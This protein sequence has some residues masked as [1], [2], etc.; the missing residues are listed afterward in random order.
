LQQAVDGGVADESAYL[1]LYE[2]EL[3]AM[4]PRATVEQR[5]PM[6]ALLDRAVS[7]GSGLSWGYYLRA[8]HRLD[9]LKGESVDWQAVRADLQQGNTA[10]RNA[11]P[12]AFPQSYVEEQLADEGR[13]AGSRVLAGAVLEYGGQVQAQI[14]LSRTVAHATRVCLA[15]CVE[16]NDRELAGEM[17]RCLCRMAAVDAALPQDKLDAASLMRVI[18]FYLGTRI[19]YP[20]TSQQREDVFEA[21]RWMDDA[22]AMARVAQDEEEQTRLSRLAFYQWLSATVFKRAGNSGKT[23]PATPPFAPR[24]VLYQLAWE[25]RVAERER[26]FERFNRLLADLGRFDFRTLSLPYDLS[27]VNRPKRLPP[28]IAPATAPADISQ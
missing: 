10:Q 27:P 1:L 13:I 12:L 24:Y 28:R 26:I 15:H 7:F 22:S 18:A 23:P 21:S 9:V 16:A 2:A 5:R 17:L 3:A 20:A 19:D 25:L 4:D 6:L 11:R 8:L 14:P